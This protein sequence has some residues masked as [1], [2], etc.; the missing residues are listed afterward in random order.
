MTPPDAMRHAVVDQY[1]VE[2]VRRGARTLAAALGFGPYE[3]EVVGVVVTELATNLV[4]YAHDGEIEV[5]PLG[6]P[7]GV[8]IAVASRDTG[9]GIPDVAAALN[10]GF[11]SAGGLG[12]GLPG[13]RRLMD[14]FKLT[15]GPDGTIIHCRK[16]RSPRP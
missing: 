5:A 11:S 2:Q 6:G 14:E 7:R 13:V 8:G 12:G 1:G 10:D 15:S 3:I 4:R 16:W 9:P